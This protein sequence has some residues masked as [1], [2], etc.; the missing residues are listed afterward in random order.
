LHAIGTQVDADYARTLKSGQLGDQLPD[1]T[2]ADNRDH[3]ADTDFRNPDRVESNTPERGEARMLERNFVGYSD[4]QVLRSEDRFTVT[5]SLT[6][7]SDTIA[8]VELLHRRV[9]L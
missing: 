2:Q 1:Q 4:D 9:A 6:A 3:I 7:V 8:D 5:S